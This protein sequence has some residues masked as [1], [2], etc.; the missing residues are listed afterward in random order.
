MTNVRISTPI[1]P[2][3]ILPVDKG[4][5]E[6]KEIVEASGFPVTVKIIGSNDN[7]PVQ[8]KLEVHDEDELNFFKEILLEDSVKKDPIPALT[9]DPRVVSVIDAEGFGVV[10]E[11]VG[12]LFKV[13]AYASTGIIWEG[14]LDQSFEG[15]SQ[16]QYIR[17][18]AETLVTLGNF[19]E[20]SFPERFLNDDQT[21][22]IDPAPVFTP[23]EEVP[24]G[25]NMAA[26]DKA[27]G[28]FNSAQSRPPI[29]DNKRNGYFLIKDGED[30]LPL[31]IKVTGDADRLFDMGYL[32]LVR[33]RYHPEI[34]IEGTGRYRTLV[35]N[36]KVKRN[37]MSALRS[38]LVDANI[39]G[40]YYFE[41]VE[42]NGLNEDVDGRFL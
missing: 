9:V 10:S 15:Q 39:A 42:Y 14:T 22:S 4:S 3:F 7:S 6:I 40:D 20:S 19:L 30:G 26:I 1:T 5:F 36:G 34:T 37:Y 35:L 17:K 29:T 24:L 18:V 16:L 27:L 13:S 38:V 8:V 2:A 31:M 25:R 12:G 32:E 11:L 41:S 23:A 21:P 28:A 33:Q